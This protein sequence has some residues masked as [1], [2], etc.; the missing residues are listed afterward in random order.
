VISIRTKLRDSTGITREQ[1]TPPLETF[2]KSFNRIQVG[3]T[4]GWWRIVIDC[5]AKSAEFF[6]GEGRRGAIPTSAS[7]SKLRLDKELQI[8]RP[9]V[10]AKVPATF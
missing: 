10:P 1:L 8:H 2:N 3:D 4:G 5:A 7:N 9:Q 6:A